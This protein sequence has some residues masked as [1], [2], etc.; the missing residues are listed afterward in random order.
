VADRTWLVIALDG[1]DE[2]LVEDFECASIQLSSFGSCETFAYSFPDR[3]YTGDVWPTVATGLPPEEHGI[4]ARTES[5]WSNPLLRVARRSANRLGIDGALRSLARD[6]VDERTDES[7]T[8]RTTDATHVFEGPDRVVHNWPGVYRP[9]FLSRL[10]DLLADVNRGEVS[11]AQFR[12]LAR[13]ECR[14]KLA[15]MTEVTQGPFSLVGCHVH[16]LDLVGH[17]HSNDEAACRDAYRWFDDHFG[18]FIDDLPAH[19]DVCLL[20]DHGINVAWLDDVDVGNH[21]WRAI[22]ASTTD[23][24]PTDVVDV[25]AWLEERIE[26][27]D[28][29]DRAGVPEDQLRDLGYI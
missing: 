22:S 20:S 12:A 14:E 8:L 4:H 27:V 6:V 24:R 7:R 16:Y 2:Q 21:S 3:P 28:A 25:R 19:T 13:G 18:A 10:W 29:G 23:D 9:Q 5:E 17:V 26:S 1:A 15:W 11:A